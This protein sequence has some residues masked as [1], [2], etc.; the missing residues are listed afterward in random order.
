MCVCFAQN[1]CIYRLLFIC[2]F[3]CSSIHW[4][5]SILVVVLLFKLFDL[6]VDGFGTCLQDYY[7]SG[8][9][10]V[11]MAEAIGRIVLAGREMTRLAG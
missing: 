1:N 8:R 11:K 4:L 5:N 9:M 10:L 6:N 3:I 7:K 2:V